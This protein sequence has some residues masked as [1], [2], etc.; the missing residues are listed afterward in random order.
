MRCRPLRC[1]LLRRQWPRQPAGWA[2]KATL[3]VE[4]ATPM[5]DYQVK[6]TLNRATFDYSKAKPDGSDL[7]VHAG[8][9]V[10]YWIETWDSASTSTFVGQGGCRQ[11]RVPALYAGNAAATAVSDGAATFELFDDFT[12]LAAWTRCVRRP[13]ALPCRRA[14]RTKSWCS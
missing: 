5:A 13:P 6:L 3:R 4:P 12:S 14:G 1:C 11:Y 10:P 2:H 8:A 7:R 9:T